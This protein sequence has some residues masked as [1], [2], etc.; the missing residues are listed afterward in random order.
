MQLCGNG[1]I[2][3]APEVRAETK[4]DRKALIL[5]ARESD[6]RLLIAGERQQPTIATE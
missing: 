5:I 3:A 6:C 1:E 2:A 4:S